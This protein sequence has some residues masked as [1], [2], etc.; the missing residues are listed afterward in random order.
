M[1]LE[2]VEVVV[3]VVAFARFHPPDYCSRKQGWREEWYVL[4]NAVV[5]KSVD[6]DLDMLVFAPH[7]VVCWMGFVYPDL[8]VVVASQLQRDFSGV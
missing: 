4:A 3:E 8:V 5:C 6:S 2:L 1:N 7:F